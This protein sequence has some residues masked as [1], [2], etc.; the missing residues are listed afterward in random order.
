[1]ATEP[2]QGGEGGYWLLD[3]KSHAHFG[4]REIMHMWILVAFFAKNSFS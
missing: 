3:K 2:Q 4:E 1:M